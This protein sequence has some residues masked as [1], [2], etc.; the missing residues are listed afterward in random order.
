MAAQAQGFLP[1]YGFRKADVKFNELK[2]AIP[3]AGGN[4][5]DFVLAGDYTFEIHLHTLYKECVDQIIP[6]TIRV[7]YSSSVV[8]QYGS[9]LFLYDAENNGGYDNWVSYQW[10]HNNE[11]MVGYTE[12]QIL[13]PD[14]T[15]EAEYFCMITDADGNSIATCP[16]HYQSPV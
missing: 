3:N 9:Y 14:T 5:N 1:Q 11:L 12:P 8:I 2:L 4:V 6:V 7:N 15:A 10:Y 16:V 13:M